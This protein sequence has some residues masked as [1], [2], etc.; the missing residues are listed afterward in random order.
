MKRLLNIIIPSALGLLLIA[1]LSF[2]QGKLPDVAPLG[3]APRPGA[4]Q[5]QP[6]ANMPETHAAPGGTDSTIV[7]GDEPRVPESPTNYDA[8]TAEIIGS[9]ANPEKKKKSDG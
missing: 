2:A 5:E 9:D 8:A 6:P 7:E 1:E 3:A 4:N